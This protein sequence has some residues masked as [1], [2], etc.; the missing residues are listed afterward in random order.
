MQTAIL[1]SMKYSI[2][3]QIQIQIQICNINWNVRNA[4]AKH[5]IQKAIIKL[6]NR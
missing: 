2:L 4:V 3:L 5:S 6:E 1:Y